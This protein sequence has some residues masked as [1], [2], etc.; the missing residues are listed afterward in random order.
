[1]LKT[2]ECDEKGRLVLPREI[3]DEFGKRYVV[4]KALDEVVLIPVPKDPLKTL[5]ELGKKAGIDRFSI[6][7][8]KTMIREEGLKQAHVRRH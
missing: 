3:R 6:K 1:M 7:K 8:I 2:S 5:R 4:V